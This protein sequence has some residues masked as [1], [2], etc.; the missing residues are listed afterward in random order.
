MKELL[1]YGVKIWFAI[2][3]LLLTGC[4]FY[5]FDPQYY[6]ARKYAKQYSAIYVIDQGLY[7]EIKQKEYTKTSQHEKQV[8]Q[9]KLLTQIKHGKNEEWFQKKARY[10]ELSYKHSGY[11]HEDNAKILFVLDKIH[12]IDKEKRMLNN[13]KPY[14]IGAYS[15][16][17]VISIPDSLR[18]QIGGTTNKNMKF[19]QIIYPQFF[20]I[21]ETQH[22]RL[23]SVGVIYRYVNI[24]KVYGLRNDPDIDSVFANGEWIYL[25]K[26]KIKHIHS[27]K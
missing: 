10:M 3:I 20:Y 24:N 27:D 7:N 19:Q 15:Y 5:M 25:S 2:S 12:S 16:D 9:E 1:F 22:V 26:N 6:E 11:Y 13:G 18:K 23:I 14:Y 21:D 8:L 4:T 17:G